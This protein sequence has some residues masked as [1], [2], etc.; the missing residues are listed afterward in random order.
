MHK[1]SYIQKYVLSLGATACIF[2]AVGYW[3]GQRNL[4]LEWENMRP[5]FSIQE[6]SPT[7]YSNADMSKFWEVWDLVTTMSIDRDKLTSDK[8][9]EGAVAGLVAALDD[10][11][12]MYLTKKQNKESKQDL[13]GKFEGVGMEL[14]YN[15]E[16][17][18]IVISPLKN[19]P[20]KNAGVMP[21]DKI[22]KINDETSIAM[23]IQEAVKKIRGEKGT[24]V[25]LTL[26]QGQE[27]PREVEITRETITVPSVELTFLE[28][29]SIAHIELNRFGDDTESAW[30]TKVAEIRAK[31]IDNIILDLR[32]N[33]GGYFKTAVHVA[34]DFMSGPVVMQENYLGQKDTLY[35]LNTQRLKNANVA[36]LINKGSASASEIVTGALAEETDAIAIGE[37]SFGKGTVQDVKDFRDGSGVHITIAKWLTPQGNWVHKKGIKPDIEVIDQTPGD[38]NDEVLNRAIEELRNKFK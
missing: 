24:K 13:A 22:W 25:K 18:L 33:P 20:A 27:E 30:D 5:S 28:N 23:P 38:E 4:N 8:L 26:Q 6:K 7:K 17:Q 29:D 12:S 36:I 16:K 3:L 35:A 10:P 15:D 21:S 37:K 32:N 2:T 1:L 9:I 19:S 34:S 31:K 14:G 11:Y